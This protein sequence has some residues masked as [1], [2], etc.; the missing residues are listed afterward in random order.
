MIAHINN[1]ISLPDIASGSDIALPQRQN[2][3]VQGAPGLQAKLEQTLHNTRLG[4]IV[5]FTDQLFGVNV[6]LDLGE[7]GTPQWLHTENN[8][9]NTSR[10]VTGSF[11]ITGNRES[12]GQVAQIAST[13]QLL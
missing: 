1:I 3:T 7:A 10:A 8:L 2:C 9:G 4:D 13:K 11:Q 6:D 5:L 12:R